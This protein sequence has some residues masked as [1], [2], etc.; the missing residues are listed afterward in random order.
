MERYVQS[1][2]TRWLLFSF[3]LAVALAYT[4][5]GSYKGALVNSCDL[6]HDWIAGKMVNAGVNPYRVWLETPERSFDYFPGSECP[7]PDIPFLNTPLNAIMML[8]FQSIGWESMRVLWIVL[9]IAFTAMTGLA[10][11]QLSPQP[12]DDLYYRLLPVVLLFAWYGTRQVF[13]WGQISMFIALM[14]FASLAML[15]RGRDV[16]AGTFLGIALCKFT[17]VWALPLLFVA[18]RRYTALAIAVGLQLLG[19]GLL[20]A[21][22]G[23]S[24]VEVP[25][26]YVELLA[27]CTGQLA[28]VVSLSRWISEVGGNSCEVIAFVLGVLLA[29]WVTWSLYRANLF[30]SKRDLTSTPTRL[31]ANLF[32]TILLLISLTFV[33]HRRHDTILTLTVV[34][35][36]LN[37]VELAE[38]TPLQE[39]LIDL[40]AIPV[41]LTLTVNLMPV[42][43]ISTLIE[44]STIF[45]EALYTTA[46]VTTLG[47]MIWMVWKLGEELGSSVQATP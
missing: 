15:Y 7:L 3:F 17:M 4:A 30:G 40:M 32:A 25:C 36:W 39:R 11:L 28:G 41:V 45:S 21:A 27:E 13:T 2:K 8:P 44:G 18:Y 10:L 22:T 33:Y 26:V 5:Y 37:L 1:P 24:V 42:A 43:A 31:A 29:L 38:R 16:L 35:F 23:E 46:L 34:F 47:I 9:Q 6:Q 12:S 20:S 14:T 19:G